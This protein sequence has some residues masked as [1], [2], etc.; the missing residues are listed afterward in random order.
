[1]K[2]PT[3]KILDKLCD[4]LLVRYAEVL[5]LRCSECGKDI[6]RETLYQL[7]E[8]DLKK[9]LILDDAEKELTVV[10]PIVWTDSNNTSGEIVFQ[11]DMVIN[12]Q[13]NTTSSSTGTVHLN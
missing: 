9:E 4:N 13:T 5:P 6:G 11:N 2:T 10:Q 12:N 1:M 8:Y 7:K 3:R